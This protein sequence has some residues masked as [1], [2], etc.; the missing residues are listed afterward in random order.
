MS[1][2]K[3]AVEEGRLLPALALRGLTVFPS[4]MIHFDVGRELSMKALERAM[5]RGEE[6]FLVAQRSIMTEQPEQEDL[7]QVGTICSIRQLL[8]LQDNNV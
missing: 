1:E 4:M 8:R 6:I 2:T 5:E 7:Y 3:I